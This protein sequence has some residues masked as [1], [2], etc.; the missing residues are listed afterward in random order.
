M[1]LVIISG[2]SGSGKT[3]ALHT[4]EDIGFYCIDNLPVGLLSGFAREVRD[5]HL[6]S[7]NK[8]AVS[9]DARNHPD[10]LNGFP[11]IIAELRNKGTACKIL[12]LQAENSTLLKR[13]S[14]TRRKHPLS[15]VDLPLTDAIDE[16]RKLLAPIAASADLLIDT[17][18][19]NLH[20]LRDLV[21]ECLGE[22]KDAEFSLLL[23]SFGYKHGIPADADFVFDVRCLPNPH[24][25]ANLR[26]LTGLDKDVVSFLEKETLV[27]ELYNDL[28]S[29]LSTWIPRF[30]SDNRSYLSIAIGCTGGQHR[31]VYLVDR[32]AKNLGKQA[33]DVVVRHR[34]LE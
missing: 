2:L 28:E 30:R 15:D 4:L 12:Y 8:L 20:Q 29:F 13:F 11:D 25:Q 17:S 32:L 6:V 16:E 24:W 19:T 31:S 21:R 9:I 23:R 26:S 33:G 22:D 34:E 27:Q 10:Q 5:Q 1:N 18:H 7:G 14:E 3:I